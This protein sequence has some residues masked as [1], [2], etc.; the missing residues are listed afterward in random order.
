MVVEKWTVNGCESTARAVRDLNCD[1][2]SIR[3]EVVFVYVAVSQLLWDEVKRG[4]TE[5]S[6]RGW[7]WKKNG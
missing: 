4:D 6:A 3:I 1:S 7:I 2:S 5:L